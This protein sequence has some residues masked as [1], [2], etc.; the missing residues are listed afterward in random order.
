MPLEVEKSAFFR[1]FANTS[2]THRRTN[3][4][5]SCANTSTTAKSNTITFLISTS[6]NFLSPS[7]IG[8][9]LCRLAGTARSSAAPRSLDAVRLYNLVCT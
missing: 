7:K 3:V 8:G 5:T 2:S 9:G 6:V 1:V 4:K